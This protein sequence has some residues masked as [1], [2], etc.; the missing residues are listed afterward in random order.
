VKVEVKFNLAD[1]L[2]LTAIAKGMSLTLKHIF[3]RPITVQYP[4]ERVEIKPR[5][6]GAQRLKKD[7]KGRPRCVACELCATVCPSNAITIVAAESDDPEIEKYP[8]DYEIDMLRCIF[9]GF[10]V[11]ACPKDAIAMTHQY[12]LAQY[13]RE[14]ALLTRDKLLDQPPDED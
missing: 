10:C 4:E 5:F 9:C 11:E 2:Y 3:M 14:A 1:R 6:R 12:E 7:D 13:E 8:L